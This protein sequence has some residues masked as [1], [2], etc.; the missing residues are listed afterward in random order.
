MIALIERGD[1][2]HAKEVFFNEPTT[3]HAPTPFIANYEMK[4]LQ[5]WPEQLIKAQF[6]LDNAE[7][8]SQ[9]KHRFKQIDSQSCDPRTYTKTK[10]HLLYAQ[11]Q[12]IDLIQYLEEHRQQ[13][14][15]PREYAESYMHTGRYDRA[16]EIYRTLTSEHPQDEIAHINCLI[17][18][19][20]QENAKQRAKEIYPQLSLTYRK[21]LTELF[22]PSKKAVIQRTI[23]ADPESLS[24]TLHWL[25]NNPDA[26]ILFAS[27]SEKNGFLYDAI[28][29]WKVVVRLTN[30]SEHKQHL[31]HL[32]EKGEKI[33]NILTLWPGLKGLLLIFLIV[34]RNAPIM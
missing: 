4:I 23:S 8:I 28:H 17:H 22:H 2:D 31:S 14:H 27:L 7:H 33:S 15:F 5:K 24:A 13:E 12:W 16:L 32:I 10:I 6:Y 21:Q 25:P 3:A 20:E 26:W 19:G 30:N 18:I 34:L 29:G 11:K 1:K 9:A